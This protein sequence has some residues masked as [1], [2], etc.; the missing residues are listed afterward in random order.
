[1]ASTSNSEHVELSKLKR[2]LAQRVERLRAEL[3]EAETKLQAVVTTIDLLGNA[4]R[5]TEAETYPEAYLREF[6]GLT[7]VQALVKIAKD[8]G[9]NRFKA[10]QAKRLLLAAGLITSR[11][12]ASNILYSAIQRSD[13]FRRVAPGEYEL[14][15]K[16]ITSSSVAIPMESLKR[17]S[18]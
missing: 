9:N 12:N 10:S 11:K 8:N 4:S 1:M 15:Q 3:Q 17:A 5:Y 16:N 13:R 7:Q 18:S 6:E 14:V 2:G